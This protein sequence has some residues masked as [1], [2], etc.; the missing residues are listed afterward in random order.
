M[1]N[2]SVGSS[3]NRGCSK[4]REVKKLFRK[5]GT[6]RTSGIGEGKDETTKVGRRG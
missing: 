4:R 3:L 5:E 6:N 1:K 2:R